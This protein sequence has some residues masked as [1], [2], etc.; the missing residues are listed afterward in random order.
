MP[1]ITGMIEI[2]VDG[3][4]QPAMVNGRFGSS[5]PYVWPSM[6]PKT[7][8]PRPSVMRTKPG[9]SKPGFAFSSLDSPMYVS[10]PDDRDEADRDVDEERPPP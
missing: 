8:P 3:Q 7:M 10:V 9:K 6:R 1:M 4:V 2:S 5:Q